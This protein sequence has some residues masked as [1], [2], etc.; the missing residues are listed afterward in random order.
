MAYQS[1]VVIIGA[2]IVGL[3]TAYALL[4]TGMSKVRVLEQAVVNHHKSTSSSISRL[5]RFEYGTDAFYSHMVK[6]SLEHWHDLERRTQRTLYTPTG[7]LSLGQKGEETLREQEVTH[8]LGLASEQLSAQSC[9]QRFPQFDTR[10]YESLAYNTEG[11]ILYASECLNALRRAILDLGGE[12][13]ETSRVTHILHDNP[14]R[15]IRLRLN[16]GAE[17]SADQV[18]VAAGPWVHNVLGFLCLPIEMTRQYILYFAGLPASTFSTGV[19]PAFTERH[20]YGFPIHKGSNGWLKA[21]SHQFG[22]PVDPDAAT[23]IEATVVE[24]IVYDL[25][26]LLPALR[27]AELAH[28]EACMYDVSPDQDFI[29]DYLPGD[30]RIVFATG[31]SGHGFKF[32][33]L[34]GHLLSSLLTATPPEIPIGRF[35]LA[36]FSCQNTRQTISV[37]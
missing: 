15:P 29:L 35:R 34:L 28:V 21:T 25:H 36:R 1:Q 9:Q 7:L 11:G 22:R 8:D 26:T 6:L 33:P 24:Q 20:L 4:S 32:G 16:S 2:G 5:L 12:I 27:E 31:L 10:N 3:S 30:A 18:V 37:A 13:T 14:H 17:I 23:H 19:F